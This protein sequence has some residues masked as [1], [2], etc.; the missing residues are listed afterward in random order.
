MHT[1]NKKELEFNIFN[2]DI[3][4]VT[5]YKFLYQVNDII[6]AMFFIVGSF[7]FFNESTTFAGTVLFVNG[8]FQ[9]LIRPLIAISRDIHISK[10]KKNK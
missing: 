3:K 1:D 2:I 8:S 4:V 10:I 6:L 7:L 9:M 5:F